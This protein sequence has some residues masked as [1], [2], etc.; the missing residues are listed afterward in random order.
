M[1]HAAVTTGD[2][3]AVRLQR[4][5]EANR[6]IVAELSLDTVLHRVVDAAREVV[7]AETGTLA[8]FGADQVLERVVHAGEVDSPTASRTTPQCSALLGALTSEAEPIRLPLLA[9]DPRFG[10]VVAGFAAPIGPFLGLPIRSASSVYGHLYLTKPPGDPEFSAEDEDLVRALAATAGIAVEN[11]RLYAEAQQRHEWL[12]VSSEVSHRLLAQEST[13]DATIRDLA[14]AAR[15]LARAD[16]VMVILPVPDEPQTLEI[17]FTEGA[18][19]DHLT[20]VRYGVDN[21]I[22]W[23]AMQEGRGLVVHD[24]HERVGKFASVPVEVPINHVMV[25]PL[26]GSGSPRGVIVVGRVELGPFTA[27]DLQ[28]A[29]GF[30]TQV[31][32]ALEI[33]D[34]RSDRQRVSILEDRARIA[35]ELHDQVVQRLFAAG[36]TVQGAASM[37]RDDLLRRQLTDTVTSLDETIRSIRTSIFDLQRESLPTESVGSRAQAVTV[38]LTDDLGYTP[39]LE[40]SGPLETLVDE[41]LTVEVEAVLREA[42]AGARSGGATR[43]SAGL[44]AA[45]GELVITV[46]DDG[47]A[48]DR[49]AALAGLRSR[50]E[51]WGGSLDLSVADDGG[52]VLRWSTPIG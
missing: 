20:G 52:M 25:F 42:F 31:A 15:Q 30:A 35:R 13:G 8:V 28:M 1:N 2:R 33:D 6:L 48:D 51:Q 3:S 5:V 4:L 16:S 10:E 37:A 49:A 36:L 29:E 32:L 50:T 17:V 14:Q 47:T 22:A 46:T 41:A 18:G 43:A 34:A 24:I 26:Q 27:A 19:V 11:A 12:R 45:E 9:E 21:S 44:A 23:R 7:E 40:L 39:G 38:E